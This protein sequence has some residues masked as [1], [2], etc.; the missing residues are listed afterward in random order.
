MSGLAYILEEMF[1]LSWKM[2]R[3]KRFRNNQIA[4][5]RKL[6]ILQTA[7][8]LQ[9]RIQKHQPKPVSEHVSHL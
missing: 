9:S 3:E 4:S 5:F 8:K 2:L 7:T 6:V 1:A